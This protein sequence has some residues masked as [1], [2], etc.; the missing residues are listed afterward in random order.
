M[1]E[2]AGSTSAPDLFKHRELLSFALPQHRVQSI[3]SCSPSREGEFFPICRSE[4][5]VIAHCCPLGVLTVTI[6]HQINDRVLLSALFCPAHPGGGLLPQGKEFHGLH[7]N[8]ARAILIKIRDFVRGANKPPRGGGDLFGG[9][10]AGPGHIPR[11]LVLVEGE[12]FGISRDARGAS[13]VPIA[14]WGCFG[15]PWRVWQHRHHLPPAPGIAAAA[16][17]E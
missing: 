15:S 16:G 8:R 10:G 1:A 11:W 12:L 17:T 7:I 3:T 13:P 2:Q 5:T 14:M 4:Q 9:A 6:P